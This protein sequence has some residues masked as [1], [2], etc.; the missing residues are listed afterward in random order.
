MARTA[1]LAGATG[2]IGNQLLQLLLTDTAYEKVIALSR[3]PISTAHPKL[4][5]VLLNVD[6]WTKLSSLKA[7]DVFCCLGTTIRQAKPKRHFAK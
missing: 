6:E 1:V 2:L 4:E 5:N 3:K 7:D